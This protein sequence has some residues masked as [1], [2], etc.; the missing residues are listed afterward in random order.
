MRRRDGLD[1][2]GRVVREGWAVY[3]CTR[4]VHSTTEWEEGGCWEGVWGGGRR[5]RGREKGERWEEEEEVERLRDEEKREK[6]RGR[7]GRCEE[8]EAEEAGERK[9]NKDRSRGSRRE[10]GR[11][12]I[13][14][15]RD[16]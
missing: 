4:V 16:G 5:R 14:E 3:V 7:R 10:G 13:E 1:G 12:G 15:G 2:D 9:V 6:E 11:K 8:E